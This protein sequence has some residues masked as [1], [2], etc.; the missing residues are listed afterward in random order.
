MTRVLFKK[1]AIPLVVLAAAGV[2]TACGG[3]P[4]ADL[5]CGSRPAQ[6]LAAQSVPTA[7]FVPCVTAINEPWELLATDTDQDSTEIHLHW[8]ASDS[9]NE[10]ALVA[11]AATCDNQGALAAPE[12]DAPPGVDV[13]QDTNRRTLSTFYEFEGG[14]IEVS[15]TRSASREG[16]P[17]TLYDFTVDLI[18]RSVLNEYVLD[19]TNDSV[20]LYPESAP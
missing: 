18:P 14:C 16:K 19:Q 4:S 7:Q 5:T 9:G 3:R 6:V 11:L 10:T 13:T 15:V 1:A 8:L 20:A 12:A 17:F 2:L